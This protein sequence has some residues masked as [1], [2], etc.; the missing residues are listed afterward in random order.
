MSEESI[1][2]QLSELDKVIADLY[3]KIEEARKEKERVR[4]YCPHDWGYHH[5]MSDSYRKCSVCSKIESYCHQP[6]PGVRR[7]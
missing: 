3:A 1:K 6:P 5:S 7:I 2:R 4:E